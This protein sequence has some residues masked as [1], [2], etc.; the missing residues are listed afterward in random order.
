MDKE[1]IT[2]L[3]SEMLATFETKLKAD[4]D[5]TVRADV[6][7]LNDRMAEM[8][9]L[10]HQLINTPAETYDLESTVDS[11]ESRQFSI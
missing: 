5:R 3:V 6:K 10:F 4:F 11:R 9:R 1:E 2:A 8:N 7:Q